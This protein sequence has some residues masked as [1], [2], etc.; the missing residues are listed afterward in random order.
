M[1]LKIKNEE[2]RS[3][4]FNFGLDT[5]IKLLSVSADF[6]NGFQTLRVVPA[7]L[8]TDIASELQNLTI[9]DIPVEESKEEIDL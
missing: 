1:D 6:V 3:L 4:R 2:G 8:S 9:S 7:K 5:P